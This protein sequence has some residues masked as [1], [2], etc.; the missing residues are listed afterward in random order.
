MCWAVNTGYKPVIIEDQ[1]VLW[2]IDSGASRHMTS[3]RNAFSEYTTLLEPIPVSIA[4]GNLV[5]AVGQGT[6]P[7][8]IK[9]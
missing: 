4:T 3:N 7:L 6:V 9:L 2:V 1:Q 8:K 5:Q